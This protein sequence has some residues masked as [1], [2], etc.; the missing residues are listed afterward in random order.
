MV[1]VDTYCRHFN[2]FA[3]KPPEKELEAALSTTSQRNL[4]RKNWISEGDE[5]R[6]P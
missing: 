3:T 1:S 6:L 4:Q 2:D 5:T